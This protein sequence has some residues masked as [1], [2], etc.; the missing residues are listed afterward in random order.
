M[1]T[2]FDSVRGRNRRNIIIASGLI[3]CVLGA[4]PAARAA[5]KTWSG[6]GGDRNWT[7]PANWVGG[8]A[9][10]PGDSLFF[11]GTTHT[12]TTNNYT[13]D[14][15]FS[16]FTF[17]SPA[18][19]FTLAGNEVALS[20]NITN[21]QVVT[22]QTISLP[23]LLATTPTVSVVPNGVL[24]LN[25]TISGVGGLSLVGGGTMNL[26]GANP[27]SGGVTIDGASTGVIGADTN[28]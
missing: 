15:P 11:G 24:T 6:G 7:T 2:P 25:G 27:F 19:F 10:L 21:N 4:I 23:L 12:G 17:T 20:G 9:P 18:G 5:D 14:T 13:V 28:V 26:N 22:P 3:G 8:V 1:N 16:N